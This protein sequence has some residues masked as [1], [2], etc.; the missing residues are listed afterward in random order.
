MFV[1]EMIAY[2]QPNTNPV[3]GV[4]LMTSDTAR[5]LVNF[6]TSR[7]CDRYRRMGRVPRVCSQIFLRRG[8]VSCYKC[9]TINGNIRYG[10]FLRY[11]GVSNDW[12]EKITSLLNTYESPP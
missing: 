1:F 6:W 7:N 11:V 4:A 8:V 3:H 10:I 12:F 2:K 5:L 9:A